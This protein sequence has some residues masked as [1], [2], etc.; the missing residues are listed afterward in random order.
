MLAQRPL[1][2][3]ALVMRR[4]VVLVPRILADAQTARDLGAQI[5]IVSMHW[6]TEP[7]HDPN[8]TQR[9][10]AD[11]LTASGLIDLVVGHHTHVIQPIEQVN[12]VWTVF[13][14]GNSLSNMPVGPYPPESQ[15]GVVVE[16][17]FDVAPDGTV[18]V[19]RPVVYPTIVDKGYTFEIK[20]VVK[21]LARPDLT[22]RERSFYEAS[23]NR[24][25]SYVG[26]DF[27]T[28]EPF[29]G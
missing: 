2:Q 18:T 11:A 19:A 16:V 10:Q 20:D 25:A 29:N 9:A 17:S 6:G 28:T 4:E 24:T 21:N 26:A 22:P 1:T 23:L 8:D 7:Q 13:G 3:P 27:L 12:G 5:V 14:M 15:D